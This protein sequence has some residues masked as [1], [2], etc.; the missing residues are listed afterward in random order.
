MIKDKIH[1]SLYSAT[2]IACAALVGGCCSSGSRGGGGYYS[3]SA[4]STA[5]ATSETPAPG[6]RETAQTGN[7]LVIPLYEEKLNVGKQEVDAGTVHLRKK[8]LTETVN[9][10]VELKQETL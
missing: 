7:E 9:Q 6:A 5:Q 1:T 3:T 10:P 4:A 2:L 8:V